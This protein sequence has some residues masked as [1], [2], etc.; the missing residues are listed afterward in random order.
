MKYI[1]ENVLNNPN[2]GGLDSYED[3]LH[4]KNTVFHNKR[5]LTLVTVQVVMVTGPVKTVN[6]LTKCLGIFLCRIFYIRFSH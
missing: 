6:E 1:P 4:T 2:F 5:N 3:T